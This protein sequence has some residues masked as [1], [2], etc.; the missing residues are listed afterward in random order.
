MLSVAESL[1]VYGMPRSSHRFGT[2]ASRLRPAMP[3][4]MLKTTS[5]LLCMSARGKSIVA[6]SG[7]TVWPWLAMDAVNAWMVLGESYSASRSSPWE[8]MRFMLK[9]S[10]TRRLVRLV[11][12]RG[13]VPSSSGKRPV[14]RAAA[15]TTAR[16]VAS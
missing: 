10:P 2:C 14:R 7:T 11:F 13:L 12:G 4:A 6:S 15:R 16:T 8:S 9:A 5:T 3:S 1:P